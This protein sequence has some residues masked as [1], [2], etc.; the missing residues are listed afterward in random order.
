MPVRSVVRDTDPASGFSDECPALSGYGN[1][2]PIFVI[3]G[4]PL[5]SD[6][7]CY[8]GLYGVLPR[9]PIFDRPALSLCGCAS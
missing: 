2:S 9:R 5:N 4:L 6:D 8:G 7:I 3:R 1:Q